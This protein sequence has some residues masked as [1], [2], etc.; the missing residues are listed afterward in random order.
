MLVVMAEQTGLTVGTLFAGAII[1]GI[2]LSALFIIY[3]LIKCYFVPEAG[4]ALSK[5]ERA[6]VSTKQI[7]LLLLKS[8]VPPIILIFG[9]LG[10]IFFGIA[11]PTE[12]A[13]TGAFLAF[14]MVIAYGRF[15]LSGFYDM[16]MTTTRSSS[17]V[18]V[19]MV[20]ATC[21]TGVFMASGGGDVVKDFILGLGLGKWGTYIVMM[22][23]LFLMGMFLDWIAIVM[24]TF[25]VFLPMAVELGFN[26]LWF[27]VSVAV[28]LQDSFITPPFGYN[29]FYMKGCAPPEIS[30]GDI[31]K[32][33]FPFWKLMEVGL[34]IVCIFPQTITWLPSILVK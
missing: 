33:S 31:I 20:G 26:K 19:V 29:L 22:I 25:P 1:P 21:F 9:V 15:S 34:I 30:M 23:I 4:P 6:K 8:M 10:A 3:I 11:T 14:L 7:A 24:L 32:G 17:M 18:L 16:V 28:M 27:V 2:I 13:G 12:A 5:E